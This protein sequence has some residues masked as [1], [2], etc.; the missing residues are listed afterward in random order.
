[1]PSP[2]R[3]RRARS[4]LAVAAALGVLVACTPSAGTTSPPAD[5]STSVTSTPTA[6]PTSFPQ[7]ETRWPI[8]H[9]VFLMK[10]NRSFDH[11]FGTFPGV[12]GV[13]VG[14]DHGVQRPLTRASDQKVPDV[15][16][17]WQCAVLAYNSGRMDGFNQTENADRFAYTQFRAE[18]EP[19]YW[20][21]AANNVLA[22][23][24][25]S[26][27]R[28]PSYANHFYMI[29]GQSAGAH[30]NPQRPPGSLTWGCDAPEGEKVRVVD[31]Q[32]NVKWVHPCFDVPTVADSLN[33]KGVPWAYYAATS[34]QRGYIWSAYSTIKHVFYGPQWQDHVLPANNV[35]QDIQTR[36]L[37]AVT[38]I[39][40]RFEYSD[41]PSASFC[42]GEN[43]TTKVIDAIMRSPQWKSTAIFLTWDEWG[44]FYDHVKPPTIDHF[45]LGFRVPL[46]V[47]SPYAKQGV[48][49][50]HVGEFS[51]VTRFIE[52]NWGLPTLTERDAQAGD[53]T[54]NFDFS[55]EPRP[56]DPLPLRTDCKGSPWVLRDDA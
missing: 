3:F 5:T 12:D 46:I 55:Q 52:E 41:H 4:A 49:D 39:T 37:P 44:G 54:W 2:V 42:Y 33:H 10:E 15:P 23:N 28:G 51:S 50:H 16:H 45:G 1:M 43:W 40:P 13:S 19:N 26:S 35:I 29:A 47:L 9:V 34:D 11:M 6:I 53:L 38:W 24:F 20:H 31:E 21:W 30:D 8:K 32:G 17:C 36:G 7:T 27:E 14:Y 18:D 22:D 48:I 25:Y 56:P